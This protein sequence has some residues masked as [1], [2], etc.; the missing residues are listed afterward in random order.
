MRFHIVGLGILMLWH[1]GYLVPYTLIGF[2]GILLIIS[3]FNLLLDK[4]VKLDIKKSKQGKSV[5][6]KTDLNNQT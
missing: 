4:I 3:A 1:L 5:S 6:S 2:I